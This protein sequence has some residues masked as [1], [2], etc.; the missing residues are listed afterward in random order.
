M[1]R[2]GRLVLTVAAVVALAWV[3]VL[4]SQPAAG[5]ATLDQGWSQSDRDRFY[6]TSQ[7]S[8]LLPYSWYV[9]LEQPGGTAPFNADHL[10]RYGYLENANRE[11]NPD[12]LPLGFVKDGEEDWLG[13]TCAACHTNE[14][15]YQG[16]S[17]RVDGGPTDADTWAFLSDLD[18][19]L[20]ETA[21]SPDADRYRRFA[22]AVAMR[23][24][25]PADSRLYA[26]LKT[27][28]SAFTKFVNSSRTEVLWGRARLDAFG[29]IFNRATG[30]DLDNWGNTRPPDAPV[31][32]PFLWDTH[33][34]DYV[35][36]N[37]SAPNTLAFQRLG[38]NVGEVLGVFAHV[39]FP[40]RGALFVNSSGRPVQLLDIEHRLSRLRS[41]AWPQELG[42]ID[43][44]LAARGAAVYQIYCV[45]C[46]AL[47]PR[48]KP[49]GRMTIVRTPIDEVGTDPLMANNA[50]GR[51]AKAGILEGRRLPLSLKKMSAEPQSVELTVAIA[52]GVILAPPNWRFRGGGDE[53]GLFAAI[54]ADEDEGEKQTTTMRSPGDLKEMAEQLVAQHKD[55]TNELRYKAR[56]LD[57]IWATAPYLHNGSVPNLWQLVQPKARATTFYVGTREFDPKNVG[58]VTTAFPGAFQFDTSKRGNSNVGHDSYLPAA[59]SDDDR[60]ALVEYMKT[61]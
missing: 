10:S 29:M 45:S 8:Q 60:W 56:P 36:W 7:G 53:R 42:P 3:A 38:R 31:S 6:T 49:I 50:K 9:A 26:D 39:D 28:S 22:A 27:F 43:T 40:R 15:R 55:K 11:L 47:T 20:A 21:A 59:V 33:W 4:R 52:M 57:G 14:V 25:K 13:L 54:K 24:G 46:H 12:S 51:I 18:R 34:H 61:L 16:R 48:D 23:T 37:G 30:I 58:F 41:P 35:Q 44:R 1:G 17:W 2:S 32:L 19:A 5:P